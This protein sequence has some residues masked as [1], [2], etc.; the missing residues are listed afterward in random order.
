MGLPHRWPKNK[1]D[2]E[3]AREAHLKLA[4]LA[5]QVSYLFEVHVQA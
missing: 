5:N 4:I 3:R 2:K 1:E